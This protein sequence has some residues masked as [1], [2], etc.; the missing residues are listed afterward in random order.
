MTN[1]G[2]VFR[3]VLCV[4]FACCLSSTFLSAQTDLGTVRGHVQD[5]QSQ[6]ITGASVELRNPATDFDRKVQTDSS[7]NYSFIGVPLT[8][9]YV[10]NVSAPQFKPVEQKDL[11]LR[12]G[13]RPCSTS[14]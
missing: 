13:G 3:A 12:A 9:E 4:L 11:L 2:R 8:G 6:A 10:I 1:R 5:Q 7:G 14:R